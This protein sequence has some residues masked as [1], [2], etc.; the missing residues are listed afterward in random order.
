M[1]KSEGPQNVN[2]ESPCK[3]K[4]IERKYTRLKHQSEQFWV[5]EKTYKV[6][7]RPSA[8][9]PPCMFFCSQNSSNC[10]LRSRIFPFNPFWL[11]GANQKITFWGPWTYF[12]LI[13]IFDF[14]LNIFIFVIFLYRS[15][16]FKCCFLVMNHIKHR[17]HTD[18][19]F[20]SCD[21][22]G[23]RVLQVDTT[24]ASTRHLDVKLWKPSMPKLVAFS[25][26]LV[27]V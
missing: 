16:L 14:D 23:F 8:A 4:W 10:C 9:A 27:V 21:G 26:S 19:H 20:C 24:I 5:A 22:G 12:K 2:F 3:P 18:S 17:S 13:V 25:G 1:S 6:G 7:R 15:K 11:A